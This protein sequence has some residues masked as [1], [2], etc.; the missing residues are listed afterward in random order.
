MDERNV[1]EWLRPLSVPE[2]IR[3]LARMYSSLTVYSRELFLPDR[4]RKKE[5]IVIEMLHGMNELHHTISNW[6]TSYTTDDSKAFPVE[7]LAR[8]LSQIATHY[9]ISGY[10]ASAVEFAQARGLAN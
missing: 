8:Q 1:A 10:L 7:V 2:R 9:R 6:L 4:F 5:T 3:A